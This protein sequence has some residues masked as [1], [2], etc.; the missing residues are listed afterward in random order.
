MKTILKVEELFFLFLSI[1]LFQA[2]EY[3]WWW[4]A[5]LFFAPDLGIAG[6]LA[7]PRAGAVVYNLLHHRGLAV[8]LYLLGAWLAG[9]PLQLAGLIILGHSSFDR[10]LGYGLKYPDSFQHT[11]LGLIGR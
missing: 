8:A 6:Y 2:L 1:Y 9:L 4:Y 11:H 7:G 3:A 10:V 5:L